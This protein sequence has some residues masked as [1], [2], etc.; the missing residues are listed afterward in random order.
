MLSF[1]TIFKIMT[2]L[3]TCVVLI[4]QGCWAFGR[5]SRLWLFFDKCVVLDVCLLAGWVQRS[6]YFMLWYCHIKEKMEKRKTILMTQL[7]DHISLDR[8]FI[9]SHSLLAMITMISVWRLLE[10]GSHLAF[11]IFSWLSYDICRQ[12][13]VNSFSFNFVLFGISYDI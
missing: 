1:W 10:W 3:W 4:L 8:F 5:S 12:Q 7:W 9:G 2:I 11:S 6:S 13:L